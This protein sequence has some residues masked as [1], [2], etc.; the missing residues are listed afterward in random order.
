MKTIGIIPAR[1]KSSR[2]PGKPL[3]SLLGKPMV[4]HVVE[5]ASVALGKENV[6]VAT[7]DE[8]IFDCVESYGFQSIMTT[9]NPLTGT[10]RV[11]EVAQRIKADFYV[12]IQGDEPMIDPLDILKA[13]KARETFPS[14]IINGYCA[15]KEG[16][17]PESINIPKVV[18][19]NDNNLLYMSRKA[20]PGVK[21]KVSKITYYKQVCVYVLSYS[22]LEAFG[23]FKGKTPLEQLEDI[24]ILRFLEMGYKIKMIETNGESLAIDEPEDVVKVEEA[25]NRL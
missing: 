13:K 20:I 14:N 17:N 15:L 1:Y 7:D 9:E 12:N 25:M 2:Y 23:T 4:I 19:D 24:E 6:W 16:E 18:F 11:W 10:D 22:E 3:V 8:R 5:R 21:G